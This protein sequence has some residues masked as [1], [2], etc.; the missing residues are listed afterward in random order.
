MKIFF[1]EGCGI[2]LT[3]SDLEKG[4]AVDKKP[5]SPLRTSPG[6]GTQK[7]KEEAQSANTGLFVAAGVLAVVLLGIF[8][9][10][11]R[12]NGTP[13]SAQAPK[14]KAPA[15][16]PASG[17]PNPA[18][19]TF[20]ST[21]PD[22]PPK[23][24]R[25]ATP[26][27]RT[28]PTSDEPPSRDSLAQKAFDAV[29]AFKGLAANDK[30][31]RIKA[32]EDFLNS[33]GDTIPAARAKRMLDQLKVP[34]EKPVAGDPAA[35]QINDAN[36]A[37]AK[38][39]ESTNKGD[40]EAALSFYNRA[41]ELFQTS[42]AYCNRA[43]VKRGMADFDGALADIDKSIEL[44]A[45][46]WQSHA[47]RAIIL[48]GMGR[49]DDAAP[50]IQKAR[51]LIAQP[52]A[53]E[54]WIRQ[55][56]QA[57]AVLF[58][59]KSL[60]GKTPALASDFEARAQYRMA[61]KKY[62]DAKSDLE[63]AL[64]LQ[65]DDGPKGLFNLLIQVADKRQDWKGKVEYA[66]RWADAA[67]KAPEASNALAWELLTAKDA[68]LRDPKAALPFAQKAADLANNASAPILDTLALALFQNGKKQEALEAERKAIGLLPAN[69]TPEIKK[70]YEKRLREMESTQ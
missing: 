53:L 39:V 21:K 4:S 46:L 68:A 18:T 55:N 60:E 3:D 11:M 43:N 40:L 52:D 49:P 5:P 22:S 41:L 54:T 25:P 19:T 23:L 47:N 30:A 64:R 27:A 13:K 31:G 6:H 56:G 35:K 57:S 10:G 69:T 20:G 45:N 62:D 16:N 37:F 14:P 34:A 17:S 44:N 51:T 29:T 63:E 42:E 8:A 36:V 58:L 70:D 7:S 2:R 9:W 59:G 61:V 33:Y 15:E 1:C 26:A 28:A 32:L 66:R 50:S 65:P 48:L 67:P 24:D 38:G 12:D